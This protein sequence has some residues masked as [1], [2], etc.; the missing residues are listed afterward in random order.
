MLL[1][2]GENSFHTGSDI[3]IAFDRK[4]TRE[5]FIAGGST[6]VTIDPSHQ[7]FMELIEW[8]SLPVNPLP[9]EVFEVREWERITERLAALDAVSGML[10]DLTEEQIKVFEESVKRRPFFK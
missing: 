5:G 3:S 4:V 2:Y 10:N 9:I 1:S 7:L 8:K 6:A